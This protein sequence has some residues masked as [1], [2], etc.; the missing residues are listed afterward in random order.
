MFPPREKVDIIFRE[1][2]NFMILKIIVNEKKNILKTRQS[3]KHFVYIKYELNMILCTLNVSYF[4]YILLYILLNY[5]NNNNNKNILIT[6]YYSY[7][8]NSTN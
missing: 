1:C 6:L 2:I 7:T 5:T 4:P 8:L 3:V